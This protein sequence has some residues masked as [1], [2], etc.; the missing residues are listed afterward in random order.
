MF[1]IETVKKW[2]WLGT[3][4]LRSQFL[5]QA[6]ERQETRPSEATPW[7][8]WVKF[9]AKKRYETRILSPGALPRTQKRLTNSKNTWAPDG[10][11]FCRPAMFVAHLCRICMQRLI[12]CLEAHIKD[13][14]TKAP[15]SVTKD[16]S[17]VAH[18]GSRARH[19]FRQRTWLV[20]RKTSH[21]GLKYSL[22]S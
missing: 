3:N 13:R 22:N 8:T 19:C 20:G 2:T 18:R 14:S 16:V 5:P 9:W 15:K 10:L 21:Q 12:P 1:R 6:L 17:T 7:E 11:S 4:R